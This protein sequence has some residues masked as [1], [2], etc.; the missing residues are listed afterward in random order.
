[1]A[2]DRRA[3]GTPGPVID[4]LNRAIVQSVRRPSS[5]NALQAWARCGG[6]HAG[7]IWR[8]P[9][10]GTGHVVESDQATGI[11]ID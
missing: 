6:E 2:R 3:S 8:L 11:K 1:M 10:E 4:R 7:G 5:T 9:Q